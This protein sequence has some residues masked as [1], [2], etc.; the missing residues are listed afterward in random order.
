[1]RGRVRRFLSSRGL[2]ISE[3][4]RENTASAIARTVAPDVFEGYG[5]AGGD[6][7]NV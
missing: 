1:M 3:G 6:G 7:L 5:E 4:L 2:E